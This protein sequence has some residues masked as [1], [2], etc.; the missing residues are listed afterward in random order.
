MSP[1]R[2]GVPIPLVTLVASFAIVLVLGAFVTVP[3]PPPASEGGKAVTHIMINEQGMHIMTTEVGTDNNGVWV[4]F[5]GVRLTIAG[6]DSPES[7]E[8]DI[9]AA[10]LPE[11]WKIAPSEGWTRQHE[12]SPLCR[13]FPRPSQTAP[14]DIQLVRT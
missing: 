3:P 8:V 2:G 13:R 12:Q 9:C 11:G 5:P 14:V 1:R 7:T 4:P 6:G 10:Q